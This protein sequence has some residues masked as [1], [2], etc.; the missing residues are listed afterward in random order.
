MVIRIISF[1]LRH[2]AWIS[3]GL[4]GVECEDEGRDPEA[5]KEASGMLYKNKGN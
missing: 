2:F 1:D 3:I 5:E 4:I